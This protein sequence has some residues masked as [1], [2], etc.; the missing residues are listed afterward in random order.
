MKVHYQ[1]SI[2]GSLNYFYF[3][4]ISHTYHTC[5]YISCNSDFIGHIWDFISYINIYLTIIIP[6]VLLLSSLQF[7]QI[8]S[9]EKDELISSQLCVGY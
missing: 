2:I 6:F 3:S 7:N 1:K 8:V 5:N 4:S 9:Q